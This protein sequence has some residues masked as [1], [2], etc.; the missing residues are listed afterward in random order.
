MIFLVGN[1]CDCKQ[2]PASFEKIKQAALKYSAKYIK[3]SCK[4]WNIDEILY[5]IGEDIIDS[6]RTNSL[7]EIHQA[8]NRKINHNTF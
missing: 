3:L 6:M 2:R 7:N 5:E 8:Y 4:E 1:K